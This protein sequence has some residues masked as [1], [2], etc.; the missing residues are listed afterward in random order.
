MNPI[1]LERKVCF[2]EMLGRTVRQYT[3]MYAL[4]TILAGSSVALSC[5]DDKKD[6][7]STDDDCARKEYCGEK[8]DTRR[9]CGEEYTTC[10]HVCKDLSQKGQTLQAVV[11]ER[12]DR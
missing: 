7:C 4:A 12:C 8:C 5:G 10:Y 1:N 6:E 2:F 11:Y 9:S 3:G